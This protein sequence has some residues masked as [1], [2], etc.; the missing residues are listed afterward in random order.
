MV[1]EALCSTTVWQHVEAEVREQQN[2]KYEWVRSL[3][4]Y[5]VLYLPWIDH[6]VF[7]DLRR[8]GR[9]GMG[10][11]WSYCWMVSGAHGGITSLS[12]IFYCNLHPSALFSKRA[13]FSFSFIAA[14]YVKGC[15]CRCCTIESTSFFNGEIIRKGS[16]YY[17]IYKHFS[18]I[19]FIGMFWKS[20][21]TVFA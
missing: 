6:D 1:T 18:C 8:C 9:N 7:P 20:K 19:Y 17:A 2:Y 14:I 13:S 3:T 15:R 10:A 11:D 21:Y 5:P 16:T 12:R 4:I